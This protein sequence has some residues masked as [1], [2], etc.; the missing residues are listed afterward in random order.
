MNRLAFRIALIAAGIGGLA[1]LLVAPL[2]VPRGVLVLALVLASGV[3]AYLSAYLLVAKR[4]ELARKTLR[5]ARKRRFEALA[6][7][8]HG[9]ERDELD[10][11]IEQVY[12]AGR[13]LQQEIERLTK[14][15]NYRREFLGDVSHELKTPIFAISGFAESLL[16][17]ALD[18]ERVNRR[19]IEKIHRNADRLAALTRDLTEIS[20]LETGELTMTLE[21][22]ALPDLVAEILERLEVAAVDAQ[23]TLYAECAP[24]LPQVLGDHERL[25]QVLENLVENAI[26]YNQ[27]GG[28]VEVV[29]RALP[30]GRV[31]VAVVDDGIG[32]PQ[33]EIPRLTERFYRVDRSRS[34]A[35]G[36]T[37][38]GLAIV[39]HILEAHQTQLSV[40]SAPGYGSSFS[41]RL[42]AETVEALPDTVSVTEAAA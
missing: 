20:R 2:A 27:P 39:K 36:G 12:R 26:K 4:M 37:G 17:G 31:R 6:Q 30:S 35:Q 28:N 1:G 24:G 32:I 19:F 15:E 33:D 22:I 8:Q 10:A 7:L 21:P 11:L 5:A 13:A 38:L 3:A 29:A 25:S 41:F 34:R 18:D 16:D 42:R 23:V 40:E 9:D 14:L